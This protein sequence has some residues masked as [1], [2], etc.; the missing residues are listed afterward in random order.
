MLSF[1]KNSDTLKNIPQCYSV[2]FEKFLVEKNLIKLTEK[3]F[4]LNSN[5]TQFYKKN[6]IK[7]FDELT[8][9]TESPLGGIMNLGLY[10]LFKNIKK[11]GYKVVLDG[12]GLDEILGGYDVSHLIYLHQLKKRLQKFYKSIKKV[13]SF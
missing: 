4:N 12:T 1:Y 7:N 3:Y 13:F 10:E 6:L 5:F 11:D 8:T 2:F 9:I